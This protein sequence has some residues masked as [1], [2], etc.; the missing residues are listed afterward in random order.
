MI[1]SGGISNR[2]GKITET[3]RISTNF[4]WLQ[5]PFSFSKYRS[6]A[7]ILM[8]RYLLFKFALP[9]NLARTYKRLVQLYR[10]LLRLCRYSKTFLRTFFLHL[11]TLSRCFVHAMPSEIDEN[12]TLT[13]RRVRHL[14][15]MV[16]GRY[17]LSC[18][19]VTLWM[20]HH[21]GCSSSHS[22]TVHCTS[23]FSSWYM[24]CLWMTG[25]WGLQQTGNQD[26][27]RHYTYM[28]K[29]Y[30][31]LPLLRVSAA[32]PNLG[33]STSS[34][35]AQIARKSPDK[36]QGAQSMEYGATK[37]KQTKQTKQNIAAAQA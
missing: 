5:E 15:R 20:L 13:D 27:K 1:C 25:H 18:H 37:T 33:L 16:L 10:G 14:E 26:W 17:L 2:N 29:S 3:T 28:Q 12:W 4:K 21:S 23:L 32:K 6:L 24:T 36:A 19:T 22:P 34:L 8:S 9:F 31:Y 7:Y 11:C 30:W 35:W